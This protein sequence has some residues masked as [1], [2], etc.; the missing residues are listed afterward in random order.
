MVASGSEAFTESKGAQRLSKRVDGMV[1]Q[2][3]SLMTDISKVRALTTLNSPLN[4]LPGN[5]YFLC[6]LLTYFGHVTNKNYKYI[7][8]LAFHIAIFLNTMIAYT[9]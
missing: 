7:R 8:C 2:L 3:E 4:W 9:S 5:F 1:S 6:H